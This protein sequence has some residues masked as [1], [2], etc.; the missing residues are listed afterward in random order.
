MTHVH[1]GKYG[2]AAVN[3]ILCLLLVACSGGGGGSDGD[4]C[5]IEGQNRF[6]HQDML[7]RYYWY[8]RLPPIIPYDSFESPQQ[9]VEYLRYEPFDRFSYVAEK[10]SFSNLFNEG[11]YV[12]FGFSFNNAVAD[13]NIPGVQ[14]PH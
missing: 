7:E 11:T 2:R 10:S 9:T 12:G 1:I 5:D 3:L 6:V 8:D 4:S 13:I 14:K